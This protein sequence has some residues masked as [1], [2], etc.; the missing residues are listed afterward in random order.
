MIYY[1]SIMPALLE[2]LVHAAPTEADA[3]TA[4]H[5]SRQLAQLLK[6]HETETLPLRIGADDSASVPVSGSALRVFVQVL[7]AM[8][9]GHT[10]TVLSAEQELSPNEAAA[11]LGMSRPLLSRLLDDKE[12]PFRYVGAHKRI[13]FADV[14]AFRTE[15]ERQ[16]QILDDLTAQA[17][18]LNM[19]Y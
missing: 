14:A 5:A 15:Q 17:Q 3:A 18:E 12:I 7:E 8:S 1:E 19:G 11:F 16:H 9:K 13:R 2:P 6:G 10:V 4:R